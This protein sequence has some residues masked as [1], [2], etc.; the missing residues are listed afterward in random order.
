[1]KCLHNRECETYFS[2]GF[3]LGIVRKGIR[4]VVSENKKVCKMVNF[5]FYSLF[6]TVTSICMATLGL[7]ITE[8]IMS[9][10]KL[11]QPILFRYRTW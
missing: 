6:K 4:C 3:H 7:K 5:S 9:S 8:T 10:K 1:M 2:P 11:P